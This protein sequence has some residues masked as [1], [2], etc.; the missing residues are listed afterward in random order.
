[1]LLFECNVVRPILTTLFTV[2]FF[3]D[4]LSIRLVNCTVMTLQT[5][6][7][8]LTVGS[9]VRWDLGGDF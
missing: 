4:C 6:V 5:R 3:W 7:R 1:M 9:F 8:R 2:P